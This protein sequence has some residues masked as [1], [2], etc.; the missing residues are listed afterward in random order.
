LALKA[1]TNVPLL[2]AMACTIVEEKLFDEAALRERVSEWDQFQNF[3][4]SFSPE[5]MAEICGVD[6]ELIRQAARLYATSKPAMCFH[7]LGVT[8]HSQGTEGVMCLV[9]LALLTGNFGKRGSGVNP[10]RGQ[11]NV[12]G[13]A[14]MG[15]DPDKLTGYIG[16]DQGRALFEQVWGA[17]LPNSK[18]LNLMEMIDAA[19]STSLKALWAI[20]YDVALTNPNARETVKALK[21]LD[22]VIVQDLFLNEIAREFGSV[23]LPAASS[24]EKDGTFM[25]SERRV[26][27]V[28]KA[29]DVP[30]Q[31][32]ADWE[33]IC[34]IARAMGKGDL[35]NFH[36]PEQIW[37]E[38]RTVWPAGQGITYARLE[39]RGLQWPCPEVDHPG[40]TVLHTKS[41]AG[42]VHAPLKRI[43]FR[44]THE[45]ISPEFPFLLTTGRTLYQFNAGTMTRRTAN[46]ELRPS[47]TLDISPDD[48]L[49]LSFSNGDLIRIR[50]RH[51]DA[52][53]PIRIDPSIKSGELFA[54]FHTVRS[55]LNKLV[56]A[57]RDTVTQTPEYK[58][59]AVALEIPET[60]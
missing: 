49:R 14:H 42:E 44:A 26:Q 53:L 34:D 29:V 41:F 48:A 8:E 7:G 32:K 19:H 33:V 51:G 40:T 56:G 21:A 54:T 6:A 4:R 2:N 36:S 39:E 28:R 1:G 10:L 37:E 22:F 38:I 27:R 57:E 35:F 58:V 30:G 15:C 20:G 60:T 16:L 17:K 18:G 25:N 9:N 46:A 50:S 24:F 52:V 47:D 45:K 23:F 59:V 12:Q 3:I 5:K 13:S 31:A 11:N 55:Y 43:D